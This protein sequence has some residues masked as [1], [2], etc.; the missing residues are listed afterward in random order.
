[1]PSLPLRSNSTLSRRL[2]I[3]DSCCCLSRVR[4]SLHCASASP[5]ACFSC[6]H[7]ATAAL[8]PKCWDSSYLST[9]QQ[10]II[11]LG[12]STWLRAWICCR[13]RSCRP[14][15]VSPS[16]SSS[17]TRHL[18]RDSNI[19][20]CRLAWPTMLPQL[21]F[22]SQHDIDSTWRCTSS[23]RPNLNM[24][25]A[26]HDTVVDM[27]RGFSTRLLLLHS[28]VARAHANMKAKSYLGQSQ[29]QEGAQDGTACVAKLCTLA[30]VWRRGHSAQQPD[31]TLLWCYSHRLSPLFTYALDLRLGTALLLLCLDPLLLS[32]KG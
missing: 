27:Q 26:T 14:V 32:L 29:D 9:L 16:F 23:S 31:E 7:R 28:L 18:R 30:S 25:H 20:G 17:L 5:S 22:S 21:L 3:S 11:A 10:V 15:R 4:A 24:V 2:A 8:N 1:M 6:G 13:A 19:D 12:Q